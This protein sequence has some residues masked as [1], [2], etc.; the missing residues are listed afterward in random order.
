M[1]FLSHIRLQLA[2]H[3]WARCCWFVLVLV[4]A[5]IAF[6][7]LELCHL[8]CAAIGGAAYFLGYVTFKKQTKQMNCFEEQIEQ[9]VLHEHPL[10]R[11][12]MDAAW[13]CD[14][15][16]RDNGTYTGMVRYRCSKGCDFDLCHECRNQDSSK[17]EL[18]KQSASNRSVATNAIRRGPRHR[19][20]RRVGFVQAAGRR[21]QG[22]EGYERETTATATDAQ[23]PDRVVARTSGVGARGVAENA[24]ASKG[25]ALQYMILKLE[26]KAR[27]LQDLRDLQDGGKELEPSERASLAQLPELEDQIEDLRA[28]REAERS[29]SWRKPMPKDASKHHEVD[30][31]LT[32]D[33]SDN[34]RAPVP[35]EVANA[36]APRRVLRFGVPTSSP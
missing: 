16:A 13:Q 14:G 26:A 22:T 20:G 31:A 32:A 24:G 18:A 33:A 7:P 34:W 10:E 6:L 23:L 29:G 3:G 19:A 4:S 12:D 2:Q 30:R 15:C 27:T 21:V 1:A 17:A 35:K 36:P 9:Q 25:T 8:I 11:T 28:Q 5:Y